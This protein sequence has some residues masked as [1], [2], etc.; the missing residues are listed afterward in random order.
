MFSQ[1]SSIIDVWLGFKGLAFIW[2][3]L[4]LGEKWRKANILSF[5]INQQECLAYT[6]CSRWKDKMDLLSMFRGVC[7]SNSSIYDSFFCESSNFIP[8]ESTRIALDSTHLM[9][10]VNSKSNEVSLVSFNIYKNI[11]LQDCSQEDP[12]T[13]KNLIW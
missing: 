7:K 3:Q 9:L 8:P 12:F 4:E 6:G 13:E 1:K 10:N 11:Y 2:R 5:A